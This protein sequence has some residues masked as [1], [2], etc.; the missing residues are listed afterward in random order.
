MNRGTRGAT[1]HALHANAIMRRA[2]SD[3][4][5]HSPSQHDPWNAYS[6]TGPP[7]APQPASPYCLCHR[8]SE[9]PLE[10]HRATKL[11]TMHYMLN[12]SSE[13]PSPTTT[14][15]CRVSMIHGLS[16]RPLA[17]LVRLNLQARMHGT[18]GPLEQHPWDRPQD[19]VLLSESDL[20]HGLSYLTAY[21]TSQ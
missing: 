14:A 21:G 19:H 1:D 2:S 11:E 3:H 17:R 12:W 15:T 16:P 8:S 4:N 10:K 7:P 9:Q 20:R 5:A 13:A 18:T 6:A